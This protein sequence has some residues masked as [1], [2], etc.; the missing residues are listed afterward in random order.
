[1][2]C[3]LKNKSDTFSKFKDF[4]AEEEKKSGKYVKVLRLNGGGEYKSK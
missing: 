3:F 1:M 4:K 2:D